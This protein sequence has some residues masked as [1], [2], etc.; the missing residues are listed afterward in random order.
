M[1]HLHPAAERVQSAL[2]ALGSDAQVQELPQSTR[3]ALE[4]ARALGVE[5]GQIVKSLVFMAGD[6]PV[7]VCASG[8]H[9]VSLEKLSQITESVVRQATADEVKAATGFSIGGV[10]PLGHERPLRTFIDRDLLQ[11]N[12]ICAAAGTPHAVFLTTPQALLQMTG[13]ELIDLKA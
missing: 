13:G 7:L 11:Y 5:A 6:E 12:E 1:S 4:A 9:R 2:R 3:T 10:P 8:G